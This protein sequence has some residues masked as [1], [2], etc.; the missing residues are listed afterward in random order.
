MRTITALTL[1]A[2]SSLFFGC[3]PEPLP[4]PT[5]EAVTAFM[6]AATE[7]NA[8]QI[9]A[10]LETGMPANQIDENQNSAL[11]LASYNGQVEAMQ[12]LLTAHA[13]INQPCSQGITALMMACGPAPDGFPDAVRLL[14]K[15]GAEVN[16]TDQIESFTALM[17]AAVEGL[18]SVTDLLL[19]AGA[20][21]SMKDVDGDTA[22]TF[23]R[24]SG[25]PPLA[26]KLQAA[27]DAK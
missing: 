8:S 15:N 22:A 21:P 10:A 18:S 13:D 9:R 26:D 17:Y 1:L 11:I 23:A 20:D 16:T 5:A 7:G 25:F 6:Q 12:A 14:I 19:A 27:I 2:L 4:P 24:N 3:K